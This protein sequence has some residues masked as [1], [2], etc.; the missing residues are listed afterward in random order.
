MQ[1]N[2]DN[3]PLHCGCC[4]DIG[5][6]CY[7]HLPSRTQESP[8]SMSAKQVKAARNELAEITCVELSCLPDQSNWHQ[9]L[10]AATVGSL[11]TQSRAQVARSGSAA[12][13]K[14]QG[15][16][17]RVPCASGAWDSE[18]AVATWKEHLPCNGGQHPCM[19]VWYRQSKTSMC[20]RGTHS[21]ERECFSPSPCRTKESWQPTKVDCGDAEQNSD[22]HHHHDG[23]PL[24]NR[25]RIFLE[26][27][28][29]ACLRPSCPC[30]W[31][32]DCGDGRHP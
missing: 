27:F 3:G 22:Q 11:A 23:A 13:S 2:R 5:R 14:H 7:C 8:G 20:H 16:W 10:H 30:A 32:Q 6:W 28:V 31:P 21:V 4:S 1:S 18:A 19:H 9:I 17:P 15:T 29:A 25:G 12:L 24:R 26:V